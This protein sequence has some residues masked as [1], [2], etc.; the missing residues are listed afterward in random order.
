[1]KKVIN[2]KFEAIMRIL[3]AVTVIFTS[4][5]YTTSVFAASI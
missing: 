3:L 5:G 4:F 2:Q 1:M